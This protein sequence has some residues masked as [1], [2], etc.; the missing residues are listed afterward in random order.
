MEIA[1]ENQKVPENMPSRPFY[2]RK[3]LWLIAGLLI[4]FLAWFVVSIILAYYD[5]KSGKYQPADAT[6][7]VDLPAVDGSQGLTT[8]YTDDDPSLGNKQAAIQIVEF[9]D[10]QCPYCAQ[11]AVIMR[12]LLNDY[13]DRVYYIYRDFPI[14]TIHPQARLAAEAGECAQ[15]QNKFW[16]FHDKIFQNQNNLY[17]TDLLSYGQELGF[18]MEAFGDCLES[19]RFKNEVENDFRTGVA[20]GVAATPTFFV[21]GQKIEGVI[22]GEVWQQAIETYQ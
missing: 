21:N 8:L 2:K 3:W 12:Q 17:L 14:D 18:D 20:A 15:E 13:S 10:F 9:S 19:G 16:S 11:A 4:L 1:S 6:K 7:A 5:V 22:P